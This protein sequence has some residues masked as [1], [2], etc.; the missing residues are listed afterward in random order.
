MS[1]SFSGPSL[2]L[3]FPQ[4]H[5]YSP[6]LTEVQDLVQIGDGSRVG[7]FSLIHEGCSIGQG[8]T[9]GSHSNICKSSIGNRVSIQTN[10]HVT[11]GTVIADDVFVG[12][13]VIFLNDRLNG[14]PLQAPRILKRARIGGG[15]VLLPGIVVGEGAIIGAGSVV[16]KDVP[17]GEIWKGE[18]ARLYRTQ[19]NDS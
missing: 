13:G 10:C 5:F 4:V 6:D 3:R 17:P 7:S 11:V 1:N 9:I 2:K 18:P 15:S 8:V 14:K 16:T 12:P 19:L